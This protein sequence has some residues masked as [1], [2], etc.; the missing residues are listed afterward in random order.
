MILL[1]IW[2]LLIRATCESRSVYSDTLRNRI[3][4]LFIFFKNIIATFIIPSR[5]TCESRSAFP[6]TLFILCKNIFPNN[7][8]IWVIGQSHLWKPLCFPKDKSQPY[9]LHHTTY[10][11]CF[12]YRLRKR[13]IFSSKENLTA[14]VISSPAEPLVKVVLLF[15]K[16]FFHSTYKEVIL[17]IYN[18]SRATCESRPA[19]SQEINII[20]YYL[21]FYRAEPLAK[22]ALLFPRS[23]FHLYY[24]YTLPKVIC[25]I[26]Q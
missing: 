8:C 5:A 25:F 15:Q 21:E 23:L 24:I 7:F 4:H 10:S 3:R 14:K 1:R 11:K 18:F 26:Q 12:S 9:G 17:R 16:D 20:I 22:V 19:F 6:K 2:L 13:K